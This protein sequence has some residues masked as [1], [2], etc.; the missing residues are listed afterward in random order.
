MRL[1]SSAPRN[2]KDAIKE[3][4]IT[5]DLHICGEGQE[6]QI[7]PQRDRGQTAIWELKQGKPGPCLPALRVHSP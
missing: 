2:R 3:K 1:L 5:M 6:A 7:G 4:H